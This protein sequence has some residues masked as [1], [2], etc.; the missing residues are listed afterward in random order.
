MTRSIILTVVA[1][2]LGAVC[3]AL[4]LQTRYAKGLDAL[5]REREALKAANADLEAQVRDTSRRVEQLERENEAL[6]G[7]LAFLETH[8]PAPSPAEELPNQV[9]ASI[10][11]EEPERPARGDGRSGE[12]QDEERQDRRRG[13]GRDD[14]N[15]EEAQERWRAQRDQFRDRMDTFMSTEMA[16]A[17]DQASRERLA[18]L[19]EHFDYSAELM[20]Q[21]RDAETD[22]ERQA[23]REALGESQEARHS[24][25]REQQDQM[26]R[27][28]AAS[29]GIKD[30]QQQQAFADAIR[31]TMSSPFFTMSGGMPM[32]GGG[33]FG[34]GGGR[35]R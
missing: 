9:E 27:D 31:D 23:I 30:T 32:R 1:L 34:G 11:S 26:L 20:Q 6:E 28:L 3:S 2:S 13:P 33:F 29:N 10:V 25:L 21:M 4:A 7:D 35:R 24:L 12:G 14:R 5:T 18:A 22:E 17:K 15:N 16:K 19:Q 8:P